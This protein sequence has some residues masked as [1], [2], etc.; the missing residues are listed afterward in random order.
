MAGLLPLAGEVEGS[1]ELPVLLQ[2]THNRWWER[3]RILG[4]VG[5]SGQG[6]LADQNS[7][8]VATW[9]SLGSRLGE[10]PET[11]LWL[12]RLRLREWLFGEEKRGVGMGV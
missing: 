12:Q 6:F 8:D 3:E 7:D 2:H 9:E 4:A 1:G 10:G 5:Y 11:L